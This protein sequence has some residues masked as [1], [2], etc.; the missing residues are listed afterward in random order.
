MSTSGSNILVLNAGSSSLKVSAFA[1]DGDDQVFETERS[2]HE[3][4]AL[5]HATALTS[6]L[7]EVD[8]ARIGAV[9]H[10]VVHG[11]ERYRAAV[12]I[13][14]DVK[15]GIADLAV[16]A[17]LHNPPALAVI[18]ETERAFPAVPQVAVFDTAFHATLA[19]TQ[20][21]YPLPYRW[22]EDWGIRR[23]G[24]HGISH[25]YCTARAAEMMKQ[26]SARL[27]LISCHLG[28]GCS[29]AA[30]ADGASQATTMGFTPLDGLPMATRSGALDPG[31]LTYLLQTK[32]LA[33]DELDVALRQDAGLKGIS[34]LSG[35]MRQILAARAAG[36]ERAAL[37]FD[38][39]TERIRMDVAAMAAVMEGVDAIIFTAGIGEHSP[40]VRQAVAEPLAWMGALID[41]TVN[42][43]GKADQDVSRPESTIRLFT[44]H[45]REDLLIARETRRLL[46]RSGA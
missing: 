35:D 5:D 7:E 6:I 27:R 16:L 40:E 2:W 31:I 36:D 13:D 22:Y 43:A 28:A 12:L 39:F 41:E 26:P 15:Q 46:A 33:L 10:R 38:L 25:A 11:G 37:A 3:D 1:S 29:I 20:Y 18:E 24:F 9:G 23:F 30:V 4:G 32:R 14:D 19:P 8:R 21:L 17:P 42:R 45:T 44:I 34:G